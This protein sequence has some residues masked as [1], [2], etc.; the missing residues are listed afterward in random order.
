MRLFRQPGEQE[1]GERL[2]VGSD[3]VEGV[4]RDRLGPATLAHSKARL[5]E[6]GVPVEE[7]DGDARYVRGLS[8]PLDER[9]QLCDAWAVQRPGRSAPVHL[10][11]VAGRTQALVH[12]RQL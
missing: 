5:D 8:H 1:R 11:D 9:P 7:G 4:G 12:E 6:R 10:A 3:H 2:G